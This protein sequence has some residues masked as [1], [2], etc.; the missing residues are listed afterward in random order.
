MFS[1]Y[2][3]VYHYEPWGESNNSV[4]GEKRKKRKFQIKL[5]TIERANEVE[6]LQTKYLIF[7]PELRL[8]GKDI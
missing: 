3:C 2:I 1:K 6:L 7:R 5:D 4:A 8:S